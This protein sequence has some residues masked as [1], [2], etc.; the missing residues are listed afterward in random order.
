MSDGHDED[1]Q[2]RVRIRVP[3]PRAGEGA[4]LGVREVLAHVLAQGPCIGALEEGM[5]LQR[6]QR[7]VCFVEGGGE[8]DA[9]LAC[10]GREEATLEESIDLASERPP[11]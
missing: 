4:T 2:P 7:L 10:H 5:T 1:M 11:R 9:L 8:L 3:G 6:A